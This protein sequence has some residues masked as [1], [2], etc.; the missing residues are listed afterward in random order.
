MSAEIFGLS[1]QFEKK[2]REK[3]GLF[4]F[5]FETTTKKTSADIWCLVFGFSHKLIQWKEHMSLIFFF[6]QYTDPNQIKLRAEIIGKEIG[7][8]PGKKLSYM[9]NKELTEL[10]RQ[11]ITTSR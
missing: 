10:D 9:E 11:L 7:A 2:M 3:P 6:S 5:W 8:A 4:S 1:S